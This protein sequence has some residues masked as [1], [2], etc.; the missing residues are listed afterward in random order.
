MIRSIYLTF[1]YCYVVGVSYGEIGTG[2]GNGERGRGTE[3]GNGE[4]E[5]ERVITGKEMTA[6]VT[7]DG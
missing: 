5:R 7:G 3:T 2:N 6:Y 4:G 1:R